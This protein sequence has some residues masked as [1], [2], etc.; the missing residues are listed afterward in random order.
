MKST[1]TSHITKVRIGILGCAS[2]AEKSAIAAFKAIPNAELIGIASRDQNKAQ[3][4]AERF[5]IKA[6]PS[7]DAL[8]SDPEIDAVYIPLPI[9]LHEEWCSK[10]ANAKKH[11]IC[12]KSLAHTY[13]AVKRLVTIC[14]KNSVVLYENFM[15]EYHPQHEHVK[16][17]IQEGK[18]GTPHI[19]KGYFGFPPLK[20]DSFRYNANLGGGSLNDAGAYT[21]FMARLI[22]GLEPLNV[23]AHLNVDPVTNVDICG[24]VLLEFPNNHHAL[25]AFGFDHVYQNNYEL[26]GSTGL[27]RVHRAYSI[28]PNLKPSAELLTNI[29]FQ[30]TVTP[31]D[32]PAANQFELIFSDF[33]NTILNGNT[34]ERESYYH[35]ILNQAKVLE[36]TRQSHHQKRCI[37]IEEIK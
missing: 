14:Q 28:P 11:I 20:Q 4:W 22:F 17:A 12:E 3:S 23:S 1:L 27:I 37:S 16:N 29:N 30:E 13:D 21:V 34:K 32:I 25:L 36:A 8:L 9:G 5:S 19:F 15:C 18:I 35:K 31:L 2:V 6:Y 33:C 24:S 26:W 10:A 7:Y